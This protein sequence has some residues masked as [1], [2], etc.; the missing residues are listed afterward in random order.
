MSLTLE[1]AV[2]ATD[3]REKLASVH[4][5]I[6]LGRREILIAIVRGKHGELLESFRHCSLRVGTSNKRLERPGA[7]LF[8][9]GET[10][11]AGRSAAKR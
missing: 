6:D 7:N 10:P 1:Y 8:A 9:H 5:G 11:G 4:V 3:K 2:K